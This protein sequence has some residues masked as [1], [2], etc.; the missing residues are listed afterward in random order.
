MK[1]RLRNNLSKFKQPEIDKAG[2]KI[3]VADAKS[4]FQPVGYIG[5]QS[6]LNTSSDVARILTTASGPKQD[7]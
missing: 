5:T 6:D 4:D 2:F 3:K 1:L 7:Y